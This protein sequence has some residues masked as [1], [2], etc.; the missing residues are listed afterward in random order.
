MDR[1]EVAGLQIAYRRAGTGRL[2][3]LESLPAAASIS[4]WPSTCA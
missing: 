4:G 1:V 2:L 3:V